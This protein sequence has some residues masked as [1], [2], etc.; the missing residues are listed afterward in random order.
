MDREARYAVVGSFVIIVVIMIAMAFA[1]LVHRFEREDLTQYRI[2]FTGSIAGLKEGSEVRY[3]GVPVGRVGSIALD[4]DQIGRILVTIT[5]DP[6]TPVR[7][8]TI[9]A[10]APQGITGVATIELEGGTP[11]S[12]QITADAG[13]IPTIRGRQSTLEQVFQSTPDLLNQTLMVS[14]QL[15]KLLADDNLENFSKL[16]A[17][18]EVIAAALAKD[19]GGFADLLA[20]AVT[21][22]EAVESLAITSDKAIA[23]FDATSDELIERGL[24]SLDNTDST[25]ASVQNSARRLNRLVADLE[26]P[27]TDFSNNGLYELGK[28]VV[29]MRQLT[30]AMSRIAREF[31]RDPTGYLLGG[32]GRGFNPE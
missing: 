5:V 20:Q 27:L 26:T 30:A 28:L 12:P 17:H 14:A 32:S 8:D 19:D 4:P 10:I 24:A 22:A 16:I 2:L 1:W 21:T 6:N 29:E 23:D 18:T 7:G 3:R 31:E 11:Q 9:A 25:L 15:S 13:E